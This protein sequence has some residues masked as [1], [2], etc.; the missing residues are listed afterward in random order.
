MLFLPH[1]IVGLLLLLPFS[2]CY[3]RVGAQ[4]ESAA[5]ARKLVIGIRKSRPGHEEVAVACVRRSRLGHQMNMQQ[6]VEMVVVWSTGATTGVGA[7][8]DCYHGPLSSEAEHVVRTYGTDAGLGRS[9][10]CALQRWGGGMGI[11]H[12]WSWSRW[13]DCRHGG[14]PVVTVEMG[15][16]MLERADIGYR[17]RWGEGRVAPRAKEGC[18]R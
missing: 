2:S 5:N 14:A 18:G 15:R 7:E 8:Q 13:R 17:M 9:Y 6:E 11:D 4:E 12:H 16:T 10:L 3:C 1:V